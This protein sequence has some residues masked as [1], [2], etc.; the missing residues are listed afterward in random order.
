MEKNPSDLWSVLH[1]LYPTQYTSYW[2]FFERYVETSVNYMGYQIIVGGKNLDQLAAE[3]GSFFF[4]RTKAEVA[5]Q[6]PPKIMQRVEVRMDEQQAKIYKTIKASRDIEVD[7]GLSETMIIK[8]ALAKIV[9]LQQVSSDPILLGFDLQSAKIEWVTD[10][11]ED[12]PDETLVIFTKFR[13]TAIRLSRTL[14]ADLI[15]GGQ[16]HA[17]GKDFI[18]GKTNVLVGTIA[19]MGEGLNLQRARTA[20]FID[21]EWSSVKMV[22]AVDRI[23]RIDDTQPK[24]IIYLHTGGTVDGLV[25]EAL[26][27]KWSDL[28]LAYKYLKEYS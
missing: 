11:V 2:N 16:T 27:K 4:R 22:Q 21:Q 28:D 15:V 18:S 26:D 12:N 13:D 23:H 14:K 8:N 1:W 19:A 3:I 5:P 17:G 9:R 24:N 6:L 7:V 10:F 20:I 25:L